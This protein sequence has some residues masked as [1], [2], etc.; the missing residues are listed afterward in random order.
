MPENTGHTTLRLHGGSISPGKIPLG[1]LSRMLEE[2][3]KLYQGVSA[4]PDSGTAFSISLVEVSEGSARYSF[5]FADSA[6]GAKRTRLL[7]RT[8]SQR[9]ARELPSKLVT[10][11]KSFLRIIQKD[12]GCSLDWYLQGSNAPSA[13]LAPDQKIAFPEK[14]IVGG[15][16]TL[17]ATVKRVGGSTPR[18]RL[19]VPGMEREL[20]CEV[21]RE[22]AEQF[23]QHLYKTVDADGIGEWE[24]DTVS[25]KRFVPSSVTAVPEADY[26]A[27][28]GRLRDLFAAESGKKGL[29]LLELA[30]NMRDGLPPDA[31]ES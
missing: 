11:M 4:T 27:G 13:S 30:K 14:Y 23:A 8:L 6:P 7:T 25:L 31:E 15:Q 20:S 16:T 18:V 5:A 29:S 3:G 17:R 24:S 12:L 9:D 1:T 28:V 22:L 10:P 2:L 21:E 26:S 19:Q